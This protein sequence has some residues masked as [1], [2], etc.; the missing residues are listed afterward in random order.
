[1]TRE[2]KIAYYKLLKERL[3]RDSRDS[4]L[5]FTK[6]TM[7]TFKPAGFHVNYY[8]VLTKFAKGK[9]KKLMVFMPP[10]HGK[11]LS[12][13][14]LILTPNGFVRHGDLKVGDYVFGREG[15][16]VKVL[17][18]SEKTMSEYDLTFSDGQVIQCHGNHEWVVYDRAFGK[19]RIIETN[20][21][22]TQKLSS[23]TKGTIGHR[24]RFQVDPNVAIKLPETEMPLHPYVLGAWLGDGTSVSGC[25]T[26]HPDDMQQI[27]KI[28]N[29]GYTKGAVYIHKA[30]GVVRTCFRGLQSQLKSQGLLRNKH[31]PECYFNS[32]INQRL[33][34]LAGLI[35]TDGYVY[36]KNGR[37]VFS[38]INKRLID[39][40]ERLVVSLGCRVTVCEFKPIKSTS[41]INGKSIVYQLGFNPDFEI[42]CALDR[43]KP[44][45]ISPKIRRRAI[46]SIEKAKNPEQGHCIEVEGGIYLAGEK[47]IPTHNSEGSTRRLPAFVLG[48]DPH[49]KVAVISYSAPKARKFNREIQ[50]II[51]T[52]EYAEIFP[53]TK[54]NA[55]DITTVAGAWLR[56]ADECEIVGHRGGFK[57]VGVGGPLTGEPVD[58]LIMDDIYKDAK[59]AWS[60]TVRESIEDWYDTVAETRLHNDSQQLIVFTRWH[61]ND[62]AGR[63][64]EQQGI[65][66]PETNPNGW[67]VVTYQAI[68]MGKPTD[69]DPREE[70]EPLWPERHNLEKLKAVRNRNSHVFESLYQQDPKPLQGL[71][72]EQGFR[73]YDV[74]PYSAKMVRKNYT[75][76][77]DTGDDYLC[78]ICYT[79]TEDANY[80]TDILY[81]QKPMEYTETKTAEMLTKQLTQ[82][83]IIESNNGGRGFARNV[84]KQ[85]RA[86]NNTKTRFKWFHQKDN[87][88][89]RIFSK[90][91]D[92]QNMVYFPRGWDKMW[93]DFYKAVNTYMKVGKNDHDD[94][95]DTLT[96][97]VEWR[98]KAVSR[99]KDLSGVF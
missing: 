80:V 60:P 46:I 99:A 20:Y 65:Y 3:K 53:S 51:D 84:E 64:L 29:L 15:K 23:G 7:P 47:L 27:E 57:T 22:L 97:T 67:V 92:V 71:M 28:E 40:V 39:D 2:E 6:A 44:K 73:E 95:P 37:V 74:I 43:K 10:Q 42:P 36:H 24:Y 81:T 1:M 87:K 96:G 19:E 35:D 58:M 34:L 14:T 98:G 17:W 91:A 33:E 83:A 88:A 56:N 50:R 62:L 69:Y 48:R 85:V 72:Y 11:E 5:S 8:N 4:L 45:R 18:I 16:P 66:D 78:S 77:A 9:V 61:E 63:L 79:E 21:L 86:L 59:T 76:T 82:V 12:D 68:K 89:V 49:K 25:I 75:D 93:P 41:G 52:E 32:S 54:L 31:I 90:S 70:G 38:N 30:T 13:S 55:S 26:H 94:A